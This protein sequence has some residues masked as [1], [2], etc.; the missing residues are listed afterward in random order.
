MQLQTLGVLGNIGLPYPSKVQLAIDLAKISNLNLVLPCDFRSDR[1]AFDRQ[2]SAFRSQEMLRLDCQ[3]SSS[4]TQIYIQTYMLFTLPVV[5]AMYIGAIYGLFC[6]L[7]FYG[8]FKHIELFSSAVMQR[9]ICMD[10]IAPPELPIPVAHNLGGCVA[11]FPARSIADGCRY[12][13]A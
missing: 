3:S 8:C 6:V 9:K 1:Q 4:R 10:V 5:L 7:R 11:V 2:I 13:L 12:C